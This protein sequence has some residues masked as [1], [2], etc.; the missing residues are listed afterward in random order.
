MSDPQFVHKLQSAI[1]AKNEE[2][3]TLTVRIRE[4]EAVVEKHSGVTADGA[5]VYCGDT[6]WKMYPPFTDYRGKHQT[7]I[8]KSEAC[9]NVGY[10]DDDM[11]QIDDVG[12]YYSTREA[13]EAAAAAAEGGE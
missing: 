11:V 6:V 8:D 4:L 12:F 2:I 10:Y 9:C 1:N 3:L 7:R 5:T 13:A